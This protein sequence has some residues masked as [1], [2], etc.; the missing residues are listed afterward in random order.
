[1]RTLTPQEVSSP[2]EAESGVKIMQMVKPEV[3][4]AE[5]V[6]GSPDEITDRLVSILRE[7]GVL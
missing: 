4:K 7:R 6:A 1:M 3:S 2:P 5:I